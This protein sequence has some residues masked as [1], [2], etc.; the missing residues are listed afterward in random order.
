MET[1]EMISALGALAQESRLAVFRLLVQIGPEGMAASKLGEQLSIPPS[2]MSFHLKELFHSQLVRSRQE[3]RFVIYSANFE[4][5]NGLIAFLT[6]NCC[7]GT[8]CT[9]FHPPL[10]SML[11]ES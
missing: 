4:T 5:M 1:K 8:P 6:E 2:S 11:S 10:I 7:N 9:P 3:G